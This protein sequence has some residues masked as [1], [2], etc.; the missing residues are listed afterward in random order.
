[1]KQAYE[2]GFTGRILISMPFGFG[3]V[4]KQLVA[5]HLSACAVEGT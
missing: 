3:R 5:P 2:P 4:I 1:M